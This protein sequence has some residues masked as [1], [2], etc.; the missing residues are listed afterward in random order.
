MTHFSGHGYMSVY[1]DTAYTLISFAILS[2]FYIF[3]T[4]LWFYEMSSGPLSTSLV[5]NIQAQADSSP[6]QWQVAA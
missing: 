2:I 5:Y 4:D 1:S 6:N 3:N